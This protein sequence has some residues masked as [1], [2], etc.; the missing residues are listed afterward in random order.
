[1]PTAQNSVKPELTAAEL[2]LKRRGRRR[3]LG[4]VTMGVVAIVVLPMIFDAEPK[5]KDTAR[6]EIEIQIPPKEGLA[7]LPTPVAPPPSAADA[8][9]KDLPKTGDKV[10][11]E[12][13]PKPA[14]VADAPADAKPAP[15]AVPK[16]DAKTEAKAVAKADPKPEKKADTKVADAPSTKPVAGGF[17]I[18]I[19]AYKDAENAKTVVSRMK[20]A[21]LPV[22]TDAL[23]VKT[24]TVTRV[25]VGPFP[26]KEKAESA[27]AEVKLAGV[28][29]KVVPLP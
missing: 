28:D 13:P 7:P 23:A 8:A 19:G 5:R 12:A 14:I 16:A 17:V 22:F 11:P 18:Q 26:T 27:L 10:T 15:K 20:E 4:A 9:P 25:R 21:K 2:E 24:G 6:Q 1:M 29:G 3:L